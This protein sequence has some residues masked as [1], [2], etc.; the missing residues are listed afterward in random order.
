MARL[1]GSEIHQG[2]GRTSSLETRGYQTRWLQY[3]SQLLNE[4][5]GPKEEVNH[6]SDVQRPLEN[7]STSDITIGKVGEA[8]KKMGRMKAVGPDNIPIEV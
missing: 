3:F 4:S 7:G 8:L 6:I 1:R 5:K 2:R